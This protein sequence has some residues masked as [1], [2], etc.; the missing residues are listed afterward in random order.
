M[1]TTP[2]QG[3]SGSD[4]QHSRLAPS[5][6]KRWMTCTASV[7]F[8]EENDDKIFPMKVGKVIRLTPYL[9]SIPKE[10]VKDYE[11]RGMA[12]AK[13]I[14]NGNRK[15][16]SLTHQ[17]KRDIEK[18]EGSV[19]SRKG[20][21]AHDFAEAIL[22]GKRTL[23][24]I[25]EEFQDSL[26][27]YVDHCLSLVPD[28]VKPLVEVSVPLF[29]SD[30]PDD[31]GTTDFAVV[32]DEFVH[33]RDY[34]NGSGEE[35]VA[36]ENKQLSS[37]AM[38]LIDALDSIYEFK[39]ETVVTLGIVQ[40]NHHA[41]NPI[42]VWELTLAELRNFCRDIEHSAIQIRLGKVTKFAPSEQACMWCDARGFCPSREAAM[43]AMIPQ[44]ASEDLVAFLPDLTEEEKKLPAIDR[45]KLRMTRAGAPEE[46][47][48][49]EFRVRMYEMTKNMIAVLEDNAEAL[50]YELLGGSQITG[51]KLVLSRPGNR[52][53]A[54]E[55]AAETFLKNQGLK[56]EER[57][58]YK[59][60]SPT[61]AE[62]VLGE[63]LK[64]TR[65]A[66]RFKE[67]V[68]RS[69]PKK[70]LALADDKREACLPDVASMPDMDAIDNF[71]V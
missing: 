49:H 15:V 68:T 20:T 27:V 70:T 9:Q 14:H 58:D 61:A 6:A 47:L 53:W 3:H 57:Y 39:P 5:A 32:T 7:K 62:K 50:E 54:N 52:A 22:T 66:S 10:E 42:K 4:N 44:G 28:G 25:P 17:E 23:D 51:V 34:K 69:E 13:E 2:L 65:T 37:Y 63:R 31:T 19:A 1:T 36:V 56:Q 48:T 38:S 55:T 46:A 67:L 21:R 59:V 43:N 45:F 71:E 33:I 35:E 24:S 40:P 29:Y 26:R 41:G 16:E 8:I 60:I 18:T 64:V 12:L 11:W 30:N